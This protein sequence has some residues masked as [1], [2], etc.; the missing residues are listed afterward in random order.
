MDRVRDVMSANPVVVNPETPVVSCAMKMLDLG[1]RHLPVVEN[2]QVVGLVDDAAVFSSGVVVEGGL[3][4]QFDDDGPSDAGGLARPVPV[5]DAED[6]LAGALRVLKGHGAGVVIDAGSVIGVLSEHDIV[7]IAPAVLGTDLLVETVA[8]AP[9]HTVPSS[10]RVDQAIALMRGA[11][12]RHLVVQDASVA[13]GVLSLRDL[14]GDWTSSDTL[15]DAYA[16]RAIEATTDGTSVAAAAAQMAQLHIG[17]LPVL[18][19][20]GSAVRILTRT[21]VMEAV[22]NALEQE[23]LFPDA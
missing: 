1:I 22:R 11:W 9:V 12:I 17:C 8:S 20:H 18:D 15:V 2:G 16:T 13:R 19:E 6:Q 4:F 14:V 5:L 21:D 23:A 3:W 7:T 10:T